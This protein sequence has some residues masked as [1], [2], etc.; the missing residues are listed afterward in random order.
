MSDVTLIPIDGLPEIMPGDD[1]AA[2]LVDCLRSGGRS[3]QA[4]DVLALAQKVVSK[5]EGRIRKLASSSRIRSRRLVTSA[6]R[7]ASG[8]GFFP[9]K[10]SVP[11]GSSTAR[12]TSSSEANPCLWA[13]DS[14]SGRQL[15]KPSE[16]ISI[17]RL[18]ITAEAPR[19]P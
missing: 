13:A 18:Q 12:S 11:P 7:V 6:W 10:A 14:S 19:L 8:L 3:F 5:S 15:V 9:K 1:L 4:G 16:T 2:M 17:I